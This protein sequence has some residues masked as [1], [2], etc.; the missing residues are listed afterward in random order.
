MRLGKTNSAGWCR[1][2]RRSGVNLTQRRHESQNNRNGE[3]G[4]EDRQRGPVSVMVHERLSR[5]L[6]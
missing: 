1:I 3:D 4:C 5:Q 6:Q 2:I